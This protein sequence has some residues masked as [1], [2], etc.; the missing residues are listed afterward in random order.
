VEHDVDGMLLQVLD[1]TALIEIGVASSL[2]VV[3]RRL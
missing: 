1:T 2:Q 3:P